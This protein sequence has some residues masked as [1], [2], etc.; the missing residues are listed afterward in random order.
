MKLNCE[1]CR[2]F[3]GFLG[4]DGTGPQHEEC[5]K[6]KADPECPIVSLCEDFIP[7][8]RPTAPGNHHHGYDESAGG[9]Y[10]VAC[11]QDD[12]SE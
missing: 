3:A 4:D 10:D 8:C 6:E 7:R 1:R 9:Y 5:L 12:H 2:K 11:Y